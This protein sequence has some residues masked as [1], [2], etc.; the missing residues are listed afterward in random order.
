MGAVSVAQA[1][2]RL[3]VSAATV[4]EMVTRLVREGLLAVGLG[5]AAAAGLRGWPSIASPRR[6]RGAPSQAGEP[7]QARWVTPTLWP[8][9][10]ATHCRRSTRTPMRAI[11]AARSSFMSARAAARASSTRVSGRS[12]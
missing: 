6:E 8:P 11:L 4:S 1:A 12:S 5:N 10:L 2:E 9:S 7:T 3:G